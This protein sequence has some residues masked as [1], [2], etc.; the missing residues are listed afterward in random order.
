MLIYAPHTM[1]DMKTVVRLIVE[2]YNF[3]TARSI[4]PLDVLNG[5]LDRP[6]STSVSLPQRQDVVL[7][8][9]GE[10][11]EPQPE[12]SPD[13]DIQAEL[14]RRVF[15]LP[16][17]QERPSVVPGSESRGL[18]LSRRALLVRPDAVIQ[19]REVAH[20][21][22]DGSMHIPL[23]LALATEVIR[24]GWAEPHPRAG[25]RDG[26]EGLVTLLAPRTMAEVG[27]VFRIIVGH[28]NHVTGNS[29]RADDY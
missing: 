17:L 16:G 4:E 20:F 28:Y 29:M 6:A 12:S 15:S 21:H 13:P 7:Q 22:T 27:V 18:W 26:W 24:T 5:T 23:P 14:F 25:D 11:P 8:T 19:S 1:E 9:S 10:L 2:S 3:V